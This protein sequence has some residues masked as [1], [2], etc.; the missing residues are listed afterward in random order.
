MA[1]QHFIKSK[2]FKMLHTTSHLHTDGGKLQF[3]SAARGQSDRGEWFSK[4]QKNSSEI[5]NITEHHERNKRNDHLKTSLS[6]ILCALVK[7]LGEYVFK[8]LSPLSSASFQFQS[9]ALSRYFLLIREDFFQEERPPFSVKARAALILPVQ[10]LI[11]FK[12][13]P[14]LLH[15]LLKSL[16]K[17]THY[18]NPRSNIWKIRV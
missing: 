7:S 10:P 15:Q 5:R 6:V 8:H 11:F 14:R 9:P 1:G 18:P 13:L 12:R 3:E 4:V 2:D 16:R 17:E